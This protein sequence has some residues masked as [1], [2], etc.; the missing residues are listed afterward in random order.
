MTT[1]LD[2]AM[3][4]FRNRKLIDQP[5][6]DPDPV[7]ETATFSIGRELTKRERNARKLAWKR[8]FGGIACH[9]FME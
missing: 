8:A 9:P 7:P 4:R 1:I 2:W 5:H 3:K 6:V